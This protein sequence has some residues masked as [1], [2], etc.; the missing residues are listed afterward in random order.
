MTSLPTFGTR[1]LSL[2]LQL[3]QYRELLRSLVSRN[4]KV[5]Y[6]RSALGF[7]WT[8]FN[9]LVTALVLFVVFGYVLRIP[10]EDY[11]AFLLSGYFAWN[12]IQFSLNTATSVLAQHA[13]LRRSVAFPD[14]LLILAAAFSRLVEYGIEILLILLALIF[15]HH[16]GVPA[17]FVLLPVLVV[18]LV[19]LSVGLMLP[20]ATF[21]VFYTD[22]QHA[23]P[24]VLLTLFYITPVFY[25]LD[26][27]PETIRPVM[28]LNPM[29]PLLT[30]HHV[31]LFEGRW[32]SLELLGATSAV[33]VFIFFVGYAIFNRYKAVYAEIV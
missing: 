33:C 5:K 24:P 6:Q 27:V 23:M 30:L 21:S 1:A 14:E 7:V 16:H 25:P 20:L 17:S 18:L 13:Q 4:L 8:L 32:P 11:W 3:W 12:Y 22:V 26:L 2:P 10:V 29:T 9:P 15:F 28:M 31:V 19:V